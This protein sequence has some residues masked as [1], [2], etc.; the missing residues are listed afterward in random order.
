MGSHTL[1]S[2]IYFHMVYAF[3]QGHNY[4][5]TL[6]FLRVSLFCGTAEAKE[7]LTTAKSLLL[8]ACFDANKRFMESAFTARNMLVFFLSWILMRCARFSEM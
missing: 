6:V 8:S 7:N 4:N 1:S 2:G 3:M 5:V